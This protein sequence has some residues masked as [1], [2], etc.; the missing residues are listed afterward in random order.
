MIWIKRNLFFV[1]GGVLALGLLGAAGFYDYV[2][3]KRNAVAFDKLNEVYNTLRELTNQKPSPGNDKINNIETAKQQEA[4]VRDWI[5]QA[6]N[7]FQPIAPIP[8]ST[9]GL[10]S[11]ELFADALHR[12]IDQLQREATN[13][14][15]SVLPQYS[16]S[17]EAQRSRVK[18]APGSLSALAAQLGE[19]KDISEILFAARVNQLD[20]I[21]RVRVSDDDVSGP[22]TDYLADN[23]VTTE[24]AVLT[25]YT[26]TFRAFSPEIAQTL[27]GFASSPHGFIVES[28]NVQPAGAAL[29]GGGPGMGMG[30]P[31]PPT[32]MP[33]AMPGKG[34]LQTVLQ[35][36]LLRAT[37]EIEI[38]KLLPKK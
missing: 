23:S 35:E 24:L 16:F 19:V 5:R 33:G 30:A 11:N 9:N 13:A 17:F 37:I 8:N 32:P 1:I 28:I 26:V 15:V 20:G 25:P 38:V 22:Q 3:W 2:S 18:F 12:T 14:N 27:A 21:Q 7:Y 6:R 31:P 34:G 36:Q 10:I 4:Q 29:M